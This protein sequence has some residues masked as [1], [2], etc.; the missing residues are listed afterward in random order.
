VIDNAGEVGVF[1][2]DANGERMGLGHLKLRRCAEN[3]PYAKG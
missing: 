1:V 2:I 3:D